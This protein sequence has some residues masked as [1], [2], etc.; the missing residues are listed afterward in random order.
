V[1]KLPA[2]DPVGMALMG[3]AIVILA[4]LTMVL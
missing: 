1:F 2:F 4:A 3:F